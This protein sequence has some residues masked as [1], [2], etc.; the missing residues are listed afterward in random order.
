[1]TSA[2]PSRRLP[3]W[4]APAVVLVALVAVPVVGFITF[5]ADPAVVPAVAP[6]RG[7]AERT[8][9]LEER[10][11]AEP[12]D[13]QAWQELATAY[14]SRAATEGDPAFYALAERA[15]E[16]AEELDPGA[17]ATLLARGNLELSL[18]RFADAR[19]TGARAVAA[20]PASAAA[21]GLL[22]D[23][24]VE[25]GDYDAASASLQ[26]ML[27]LDPG[28][29]ALART[30]YVRELHGDLAGAITAMQQAEQAGAAL[31][32]DR[33]TIAT[34]L[35][36]LHRRDGDLDAAEAAYAR[37]LEAT[38]GAVPAQLGLAGI[39]A[40]RSSPSEAA[41]EVA[42]IVDGL[43]RLDAVVLLAD[44]YEAAGDA[45]GRAS[46]LELA[47]AM[48]ALQRDAG[49][50]V[51]LELALLEADH[52]DPLVAVEL[53]QVAHDARP[54]NVYAADALAWALHRAGR[55]DE[56]R[57]LVDRALRLDTADPVLRLHAAA[58]T[59]ATGEDQLATDLLVSALELG[60][61]S[62]FALLDDVRA[63]GD[64]LGVPVAPREDRA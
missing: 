18:H 16:R 37:A 7:A 53:A 15:L 26:R 1:M 30:S 62:S 36:D 47:R 20:L 44:L 50:T 8:V 14:T 6:A 63:L 22:V 52:G 32:A 17:P 19:R 21:H 43:P 54:D 27:D 31:P 58:V 41:E 39:L 64:E 24:Y 2:G 4:W 42:G 60:P 55:S 38:P 57:P 46:A 5:R 11:S 9:A 40:V 49:Q 45:E 12:G 61:W 28:L 29:P 48:A 33:A 3:R 59:A 34:L 51:D 56:A 35:G 10:T 25:L 13:L 23:A